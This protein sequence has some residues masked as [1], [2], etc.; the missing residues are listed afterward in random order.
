MTSML[1]GSAN[2]CMV[3]FYERHIGKRRQM[4]SANEC[5]NKRNNESGGQRRRGNTTRNSGNGIKSNDGLGKKSFAHFQAAR[6][7]VDIRL[8]MEALGICGQRHR[9]KDG[10]II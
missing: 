9:N 10:R 4:R 2:K 3:K 5:V 8:L 6:R 1:H 7:T